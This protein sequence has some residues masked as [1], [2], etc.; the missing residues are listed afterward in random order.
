MTTTWL[1]RAR[2]RR[3]AELGRF[4]EAE[5]DFNKAVEVAPKDPEVLTARG[6]FLADFGYADRAAADLDGAL[7]LAGVDPQA[8][9]PVLYRVSLEAAA[10]RSSIDAI[11]LP[12]STTSCVPG[13][14][15]RP[16]KTRAFVSTIIE[17]PRRPTPQPG[18][19]G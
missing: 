6:L 17:A 16:S 12:S 7:G 18:R 19:A 8:R 3:L 4:N 1:I 15:S 13:S 2:G 10:P 11:P 5:A 9:W 14:S